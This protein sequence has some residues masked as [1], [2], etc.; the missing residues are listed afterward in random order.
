ME[1]RYGACHGVT[2]CSVLSGENLFACELFASVVKEDELVNTLKPL[3][4][5][6]VLAAGKQS[7]WPDHRGEDLNKSIFGSID[8]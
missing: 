3:L 6:A 5:V 8:C 1:E 4:V 2:V 7:A